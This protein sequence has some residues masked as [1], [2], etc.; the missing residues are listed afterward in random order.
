MFTQ[1]VHLFR[2]FSVNRQGAVA[3][4]FALAALPMVVAVSASIDYARLLRYKAIFARAADATALA[5]LAK[6]HSSE[7]GNGLQISAISA[8]QILANEIFA[9]ELGN[10]ANGVPYAVSAKTAQDENA[11]SVTIS[12]TAHLPT[13]FL[14]IFGMSSMQVSD[15]VTSV[16]D[17][18]K[19]YDFYLLLDNSPS[20]G[21]AAT[22]NDI[23]KM[24]TVTGGCAFA[25]HQHTFDGA[26]R[27]TGD[28][29]ND[30]YHLAKKNNILTRIDVLRNSTQDVIKTAMNMST[31]SKFRMAVYTFSDV[32]TPISGLS[33]D[34][35]AVRTAVGNVDI[36]YSYGDLGARQTDFLT[37]L[38]YMNSIIPRAGDGSSQVK[39]KKVLFFVTD[40]VEDKPVG[41]A[42]GSGRQ[43]DLWTDG[44]S[45]WLP[46]TI[47]N[48]ANSMVGN[49]DSSRR[50]W[51]LDP[52]LCTY[53]KNNGVQIAVLYTSNLPISTNDFWAS[54]V[55]PIMDDVKANLSS[56]AS[57]GLFFEAS[58]SQSIGS[59]MQQMFSASLE[60]PRLAK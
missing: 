16:V 35:A 18:G 43:P 3:I 37:A 7:W 50:L 15:S 21:I 20:M 24:E 4:I 26:G 57:P 45:D 34:L 8:L 47:P 33:S 25:C 53:L 29:T 31:P 17:A 2:Y 56:C 23:S 52:G 55:D 51:S 1:I 28:D 39:A 59:A 36:A 6:A 14:Q 46:G 38:N 10:Q 9:S 5:A 22:T 58:P 13:T 49:V 44:R 40:G 48:L 54:W 19:Y 60:G 30:F 42:S 32:L 12:F 41:S 11:L 27:I